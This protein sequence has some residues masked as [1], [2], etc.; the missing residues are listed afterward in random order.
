MNQR[1]IFAVWW[2]LAASWLMMGLEVPLVSAFLA[3]LPEPERHLAA[4]GGVAFPLAFIIEAPIIMLLSAS[5]ALCKDYASFVRVRSFMFV[6]GAGLTVLHLLLVL[7]PLYD[8]VVVGIL[9]APE[10][11]HEPARRALLFMTPWTWAIAYR[12]F[13]QGVLI[14]FGASKRVGLGTVVRLLANALVLSIGAAWGGLE[15][16]ALGGLAVSLGVLAEASFVG[17]VT[18]SIVR[19]PLRSATS[20]DPPL[21]ARR[22]AAFYA[23]LAVTPLLFHLAMPMATAAMSRMVSPVQS[24]AVWPVVNGLVFL[25][26]GMGFAFNEVVVSLLDEAGARREL[27][28]FAFALAGFTTSVLVLM[29]ATPLDALWF[30][31]V[32]GLEAPLTDLAARA[33][34]IAALMPALSV[35]QNWFQGNLVHAHHTRGVTEAVSFQIVAIGVVLG[36]GVL[37][38][39]GP[40]LVVALAAGSVGALVQVLWLGFRSRSARN[41]RHGEASAILER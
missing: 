32:A 1:R 31:Q 4:F 24:L 23:P 28:R 39:R 10:P 26:R 41:R 3:R 5:T 33:L 40:G 38:F 16:A 29:S 19:G 9:K 13:H 25:L 34:P 7:T 21:D 15:G 18:R 36:A 12:R 17:A 30:T 35:A 20:N 2:P 27:L 11:L 22:F 6:A 14:R 37:F 8:L